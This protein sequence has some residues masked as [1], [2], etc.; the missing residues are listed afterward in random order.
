MLWIASEQIY[1]MYQWLIFMVAFIPHSRFNGWILY[2]K[3]VPFWM[4]ISYFRCHSKCHNFFLAFSIFFFGVFW[5]TYSL[6]F[7]ESFLK[8]ETFFDVWK[9]AGII[10][11]FIFRLA[12]IN[13]LLR[14]LFCFV[15]TPYVGLHSRID[16]RWQLKILNSFWFFFL[17]LDFKKQRFFE[18]K[19]RKIFVF[20]SFS[21]SEHEHTTRIGWIWSKG[22]LI[23]FCFHKKWMRRNWFDM[24]S[25]HTNTHFHHPDSHWPTEIIADT[26]HYENKYLKWKPQIKYWCF[27]NVKNIRFCCC[28]AFLENLAL[29]NTYSI[30]FSI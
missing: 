28:D 1:N 13:C 26:T 25:F 29:L 3:D 8:R 20:F 11:S 9:I 23:G 7:I 21:F 10:Y 19:F 2:F 17:S 16:F 30:S 24:K 6:V 12:T 4:M 18:N 15:H 27:H 14:I 22:L 5:P